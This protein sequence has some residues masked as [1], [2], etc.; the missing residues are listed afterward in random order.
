MRSAKHLPADHHAFTFGYGRWYITLP[1]L[2]NPY[3]HH[4]H[5][6]SKWSTGCCRRIVQ[7]I[8]SALHMLFHVIG[9][10]RESA[11]ARSPCTAGS[12]SQTHWQAMIR[13]T[14]V[15]ISSHHA[16]PSLVVA[17]AL[18]GNV[19]NVMPSGGYLMSRCTRVFHITV[20]LTSEQCL[21]PAELA[22]CSTCNC[23]EG[24]PSC[25]K[26]SPL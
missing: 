21:M 15:Q 13:T 22:V 26:A 23:L 2:P 6:M 19:V 3:L 10:I 18:D 17:N 24:R 9:R 25:S 16:K 7:T 1:N 8:L 4:P 12:C 11:S 5:S 20:R 14:T